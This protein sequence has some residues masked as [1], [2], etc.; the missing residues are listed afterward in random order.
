VNDKRALYRLEVGV[1]LPK[2]EDLSPTPVTAPGERLSTVGPNAERTLRRTESDDMLAPVIEPYPQGSGFVRD[3]GELTVRVRAARALHSRLSLSQHA[4]AHLEVDQSRKIVLQRGGPPG[5]HIVPG[6]FVNVEADSLAEEFSALVG[7]ISQ[8]GPAELEVPRYKMGTAHGF[9]DYRTTHLS[10]MMHALWAAAATDHPDLVGKG[11][12]LAEIFDEETPF[13]SALFTRTGPLGKPVL[14]LSATSSGPVVDAELAGLCCRRRIVHGMPSAGNMWQLRGVAELKRWI[15][16]VPAF[17]HKGPAHVARKVAAV[18]RDDWLWHS[19]DISA[20]DQSVSDTHQRELYSLVYAP[21][22]KGTG[23]SSLVD[24]KLA[25]KDTP[26]LGPPHWTSDRAFLYDKRGMT[27]SGDLTT[28]ADGT[29]INAARILRCVARA[30]KI[31][32]TQ[33]AASWGRSWAAF[34]QGDDTVIGFRRGWLDIGTYETVSAELGYKTK[35]VPGVIF[36]MHLIDPPTGR[37]CP[38]ASRVFQQ[39]VF[40]EYGGRHPVIELF[41]FAARATPEFWGTNPWALEIAKT[42]ADGECFQHYRTTPQLARSAIASPLVQHDL[43]EQLPGTPNLDTR[44]ASV[45]LPGLSD[46]VHSLLAR[47]QTT[48]LPQVTPVVAWRGARALAEYM[49][50]PA[51]TRPAE[52]PDLG[53]ELRDYYNVLSGRKGSD[54]D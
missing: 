52:I 25:W 24:F 36:L 38:L 28:A 43:E 6:G 21:L 5:W 20:Y 18:H 10:F 41:A 22:L 4:W 32:V 29:V 48:P 35:V 45:D 40:N 26:V 30:A 23:L 54:A 53:S 37:W 1:V 31:T 14:G 12:Q 42:V 50:K 13:S 9:P 19:D 49:A 47:D 27:A 16:N 3:G 11:G 46:A 15:M 44:F 39:T 51:S 33:A 7:F 2:W 34:I 8:H 17:Y